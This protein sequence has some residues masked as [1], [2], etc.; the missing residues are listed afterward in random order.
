MKITA[1]KRYK[2]RQRVLSSIFTSNPALVL[3]FD[4][5]FLIAASTS[6]KN[7]VAMSIEMLLIHITTMAFSVVFTRKLSLWLRALLTIVISTGVMMLARELIILLFADILNTLGIYIYLFSINGL[8]LFQSLSLTSRSRPGPVIKR[9]LFHVL[10]FVLT[11]F[12]LSAIRECFG[13]A[14]LWGIP[15]HM[16]YKLNGLLI[17]FSGF[18]TMGFLLAFVKSFN[19]GL[20]GFLIKENHKRENRIGIDL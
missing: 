15:I 12:S 18:L 17:P 7:A 20:F 10:A 1:G 4:L 11:M 6:L 8:T 3:G 13:S 2:K 16:P 14:T 9:E 5:P 19:R